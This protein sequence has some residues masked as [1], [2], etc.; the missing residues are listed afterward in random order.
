MFIKFVNVVEFI[1]INFQFVF[2]AG[3]DFFAS[4]AMPFL[5]VPTISPTSSFTYS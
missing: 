3:L 4:F 5:N 1:F 2:F